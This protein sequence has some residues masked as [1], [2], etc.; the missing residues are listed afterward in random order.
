M[1][2]A[3]ATMAVLA[4]MGGALTGGATQADDMA[5]KAGDAP[6]PG[7]ESG[8]TTSDRS[9]GQTTDTPLSQTTKTDGET[10]DRTPSNH[11]GN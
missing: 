11:D 10:S 4:L 6:I 7:R 1:T 2:R 9:P 3:R 8:Q 5:K